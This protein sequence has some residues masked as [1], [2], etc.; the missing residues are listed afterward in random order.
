MNLGE[1]KGA[2]GLVTGASSGIGAAF[3]RR[4]AR[5]GVNLVLV[6]RS[7]DRLD[8]LA[9]EL[10][11][12][13]GVQAVPLALDLA[14]AD[15][16]QRL[17]AQLDARGIEPRLLVNNAA[18]GRWGPFDAADAALCQRIAQLDVV[19][20]LQL[21]RAFAPEFAQR[22][23]SAIINLSSQAALQPVPYMAAYA[24]S[25]AF[26]HHLSLALHEEYRGRVYVQTLL[27]GPTATEFDRRAGA[28]ESR[29]SGERD[30]PDKVVNAS[31]AAFAA[32]RPL[33]AVASG[34]F[35]QKLFA[36][37]A[38]TQVVLRKVGEMF[39]PPTGS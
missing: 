3:A 29:L 27:P 28:Y 2:W 34:V 30:A 9:L 31:L 11:R 20:V 5:E 33:V 17:R 7:A 38:P 22:P 12:T 37:L 10:V 26:V 32:E 16:V 6:A 13:S 25:K 35:T 14:D 23:P 15:A 36:A 18:I 8:A 1:F 4:L 39:R 21:C 24:A 19:V